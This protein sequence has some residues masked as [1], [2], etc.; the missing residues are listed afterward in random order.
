LF[1]F[2]WL[3]PS[4]WLEQ[5]GWIERLPVC[6]DQHNNCDGVREVQNGRVTKYIPEQIITKLGAAEVFWYGNDCLKN[7]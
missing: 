2:R 5:S 6:D 1:G 7:E 4:I 3:F